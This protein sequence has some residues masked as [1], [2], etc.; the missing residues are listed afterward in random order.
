MGGSRDEDSSAGMRRYRSLACQDSHL[1]RRAKALCAAIQSVS[2]ER[3]DDEA[4]K[5]RAGRFIGRRE[6]PRIIA[7]HQGFAT[8][9]EIVSSVDLC[10][11]TDPSRLVLS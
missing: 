3:S 9:R 1:I 10:G 4:V 8:A 7:D 2:Y 5:G 6:E 11:G